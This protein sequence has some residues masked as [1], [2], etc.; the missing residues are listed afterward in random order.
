MH[1]AWHTYP[2]IFA[3][4]HRAL[5]NLLADPVLVEEKVDGSQFSFGKFLAEDGTPY[6]RC[7]SR[8]AELNVE[9]PEKL[10]APSVATAKRLFDQLTTG[11]AYRGEALASPKHN[12]LA[13]DRV[14]AG[15][16]ILFDVSTG[17]EAYLD[18]DAKEV[19]AQRLGL[20]IV[21]VVHRGMIASAEQFRE[22][23]NRVSILGGQN[24]EGIVVKN[25]ARFGIDGHALMGKFVSEAFKETHA[26]DWRERNPNG[27]DVLQQLVTSY[28][29][30]ARWAKSV[31]H[32]REAGQLTDSPK[33]IGAIIKACAADVEAECGA[34]I[35]ELLFK[36][37]WEKGVRRGIVGGVAEWYKEELLKKQFEKKEH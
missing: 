35:R 26:G 21:P 34:E 1:E 27:G 22:M 2:K 6:L 33:D 4:G 28:R 36:W 29:S 9:A 24:V 23:L 13:Y 3:L 17:K 16:V 31:Q 10:F 8:G 14:P 12:T 32:L 18:R 15:N 11:W 20:E 30:P 25:Y 37:A 7:R 5:E 19:E